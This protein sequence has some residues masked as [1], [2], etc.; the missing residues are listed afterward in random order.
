MPRRVLPLVLP[1]ARVLLAVPLVAACAQQGDFGRPAPTAWNSLIDAAGTFAAHERGE[2]ASLF[3]FT[4]DERALRDRAWR[5]LMPARERSVFDAALNNLTRARVLP[6]GWRLSDPAAYVEAITAGPFRSV[7]SRYRRLSDDLVADGRLIPAFAET[8]SRV[9]RADLTR[10]QSLP[11]IT[12]L[13]DRD[14]RSAAMRVAEN[15][16]LIAWV[17]RETAAR[18]ASYRYALE[19]LLVA[20]PEDEAVAAERA[21]AFLDSRRTLL[22]P[23]LPADAEARCGLVPPEPAEVVLV[24]KG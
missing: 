21:L 11:F 9:V 12:T 17:R 6:V 4:E 8:A 3:P 24:R 7:V 22:D 1:L 2:P 16:C 10:L 15:R 20:A 13:D 14:V 23:L 5:F 18:S 19:H